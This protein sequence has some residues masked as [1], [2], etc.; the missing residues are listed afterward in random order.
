MQK[1]GHFVF[2]L[3]LL[4]YFDQF[5]YLVLIVDFNIIKKI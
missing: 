4:W 5:T 1:F 2:W 3:S